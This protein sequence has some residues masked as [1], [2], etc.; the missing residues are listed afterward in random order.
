[1]KR[2]NTLLLFCFFLI[3][4]LV[5]QVKKPLPKHFK[6]LYLGMGM[7]EFAKVR[8]SL[9]S[10]G[11][12]RERMRF[13]WVERCPK[14]KSMTSVT[15]YFDDDKDRRLY[16]LIIY[17]HDL[18][19]RDAWLEKVYG[20]PNAANGTEW[21]FPTKHGFDLRAWR[22]EDRLVIVGEVPGTEWESGRTTSQ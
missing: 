22:Y 2:A 3:S 6:K 12:E 11:L 7:D 21:R 17:Y 4:G 16:E 15:Y 19:A 10:N 14:H 13:R 5:A 9:Y 1:M 20:P 8:R 18:R